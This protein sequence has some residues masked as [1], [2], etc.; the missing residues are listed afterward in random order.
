MSVHYQ[1]NRLE[2]AGSLGDLGTLL[3]L[4]IGMILINGLNASGVLFS[5]GLFYIVS[6]VYY[7]ITV[8]VQPMKVIGAYAVATAMSASQIYA[9]GILMGLLLLVIGATG[10]IT[11]IARHI[12][13]PV[14]RGVQ[15]STGVLLM[16]QGVK[17]ML[18]TSG[19]QILRKAA[20][21]YLSIQSFGPVPVGILFGVIGAV[22]TFLL[23]ENRKLPAGLV[24]VAGGLLLG[25]IL[26]TREGFD[27]LKLGFG[28]PKLLPSGF[29]AM[30]DFTLAFFV[31]VLP[32]TPM[33]IGNAVIANADL[34]REYFGEGSKKM[35]VKSLCISMAL[36]N[37]LC[38]LVGGMPL[39][40]GAGGLAAHYRFG[41]R[42]AGSNL[43]IGAIFTVLSIFL[44]TG[45]LS[46]IYLIPMSVLGVLLLFA[47]SQLSMTISDL[48]TRKDLFVAIVMLGIT[49]AANLAIGFMVGIA[50]A[51]ALKSD[52]LTV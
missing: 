46:V 40:H 36:A 1:F 3:P 21:P 17:F 30:A 7:G 9:A 4:A 42:T 15:L 52:R 45:A 33:T 2:F 44:G 13:R 19:F 14:V 8:P 16:S 12:P 25:L 5:I 20:E 35:T 23:L 22:L 37:F 31:L 27:H 18:G 39:C 51:F 26:G 34:S 49:L 32:Q 38:F 10:A 41:A 11:V 24:I 6:G 29:P 47:G 48:T 43:M 28:L 50:V